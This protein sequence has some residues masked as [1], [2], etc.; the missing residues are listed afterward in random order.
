MRHLVC[1]DTG[2]I[3]L[4]CCKPLSP[5]RGLRQGWDE[6]LVDTIILALQTT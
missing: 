4:L 3:P 2:G 5:V 6:P 1:A